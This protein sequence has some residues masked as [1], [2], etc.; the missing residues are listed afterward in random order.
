MKKIYFLV[1][2]ISVPLA[3]F[4]GMLIGGKLRF[5]LTGEEPQVLQFKF[6]TKDGR[7]MT[8]TPVAT[9]FYPGMMVAL[10]GKPRWFFALVG[11]IIT[12]ALISDQLEKYWLERIIEPLI[13]DRISDDST[14]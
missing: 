7:A 9:K 6:M 11:G 10:I 5:I 13:V 12:G 3:T 4:A 8:N 14:Q 1:K 2:V